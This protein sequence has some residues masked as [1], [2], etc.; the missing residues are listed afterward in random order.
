MQLEQKAIS[1]DSLIND[2]MLIN[3]DRLELSAWTGHIPFAAS[4]LSL[5]RPKVLVELGTHNG[6]SYCA[7]CQALLENRV[8][9]RCYAVDTWVGDEHAFHYGE[10]VFLELSRY[11]DER[12]LSIS[13]LLR[14][15]FDDALQY[16]SDATIDL[17]HIDGLHTY[18]AVR[19]D[20]ETWQPKLS[21]SGVV[22]FHDINVRERQFGVW[23]LW[24]E[25]KVRYPS[26]EFAHMHG[27]GVLFVGPEA[28]ERFRTLIDEWSGPKGRLTKSILA[29]LGRGLTL[30]YELRAALQRIEKHALDIDTVTGSLAMLERER[31]ALSERAA[32]AERNA[33]HAILAAELIAVREKEIAAA[34]EM[35]EKSKLDLDNALHA[36]SEA[37]RQA[38]SLLETVDEQRSEI[39]EA[40]LG[41]DELLNTANDLRS[42][43]AE[44]AAIFQER[45]SAHEACAQAQRD[46]IDALSAERDKVELHRDSLSEQ[47]RKRESELETALSDRARFEAERDHQQTVFEARLLACDQRIDALTA[48]YRQQAD[49]SAR[50]GDSLRMF[51]QQARDSEQHAAVNAEKLTFTPTRARNALSASWFAL[52]NL[53]KAR[54]QWG[55]REAFKR[56]RLAY[57]EGGVLGVLIKLRQFQLFATSNSGG[58][59]DKPAIEA[60]DSAT[61]VRKPDES[62]ERCEKGAFATPSATYQAV[63]TRRSRV[64]YVL[65]RH[66]LMTQRY[67]VY[68]YAEMLTSYGYASDIYVDEELNPGDGISA[69]LVILNR[70]V[71]SETIG[72]LI[73]FCRARRIPVIFDIDDLVFD[74]SRVG[75]LRATKSYG[76]EDLARTCSF[77]DRT[78]QTML[79]CDAVTVS[80][81]PLAAEVRALGLTAYV[82]PNNISVSTWAIA[83]RPRESHRSVTKIGYFSGTK[84]HEEDFAVCAH[85]LRRV[86]DTHPETKLLIVGHLDLPPD[87]ESY[88]GR[89]ERLP[90]MPHDEMLAVMASIDINLAPLEAN[91]DFTDCKSELK[92]FEAAAM[93]V[94]TI[95]SP[96]TPFRAIISSGYN[97][98]LAASD[99]EW[100]AAIS[101]LVCDPAMRAGM[102]DAAKREIAARFDVRATV[103]EAIAIYDAVQE[104]AARKSASMPHD[105]ARLTPYVTIVS[106]L[107][108]KA[109]EVRYFLEALYCQ[110]FVGR[111]EIVLIDDVSPDDSVEVVREFERWIPEARRQQVN[112][113][114][115]RNQ[116]NLGN[117]GSRN[118]GIAEA[119]GDIIVV[120]D[121]DCMFNRQFLSA[122]YAAH[123]MG[124]CD[125][126][127]G[128][129]N[130]ETNGDS[131]LS[132]LGRHE[133]NPAL[134][135]RENLPQDELNQA[136]FVNCITR[137]FSVSRRFV[138][139]KIDG[140]LFDDAF[141]YSADPS[142]GFG[143]EDVE[144]GV[145]LY[146][147]GARIKYLDDTVSIHVSHPSSA[148]EAEK[149][150]RSLRNYRRLF[151][152][153]PDLLLESRVWATRTYEAIVGW[154]RHVGANL[155]KNADYRWLEK[156]FDRYRKAPIVIDRSRRL[157]ILT[158]RWHVPHQYELYKT[159]HQFDL[160]TGAGTGI[161]DQWDWKQRPM[162]ANCR[163]VRY[164]EIDPRE[165]D[166]KIL[167]FD[168][169]LLHPELCNGMVPSDWGATMLW[170][171]R[172]AD[173]PCVAICHGTPQFAGQYDRAYAGVDLGRIIESS[174][175][176]LIELFSPVTVVCNSHQSRDEWGFANA[177]T[178]WHGFA[179]CDFP[180]GVHDREVLTMK[181]DALTNRPHYNG[182]FAYEKI[183]E[184]TQGIVDISCLRTPDPQGYPAD[185]AAWA[186][187]KYQNYVRE[188]GRYKAYLNT[189]LR[190]PM[191]RS[192]G[193]AMMAGLVSVSMRNH[194]V[195]L[196]IKNGANGF[197]GDSPAELAEQLVWLATHPAQA[198]AMR[199]A[200]RLTAMQ[201]FNQDRYLADWSAL[202]K[203][204][205]G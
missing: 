107:Y 99:D 37:K 110:D 32:T 142:S 171:L 56:A 75:L 140:D 51:E 111:Y 136:S 186:F 39:A 35:L 44:M 163:M 14:M 115:V 193:E 133:A 13:R 174:R 61:A 88:E 194:D 82:L 146:R 102:G 165:Y 198:E 150:L 130:I 58:K 168:E 46:E 52:V 95:A 8:D 167:H 42:R 123:S 180:P 199:R 141:S 3:P 191:P 160:M 131:P 195:D 169:N 157:R 127:I 24:D 176:E 116:K 151:E 70:I 26:I 50:L 100:Y 10:D 105:S 21:S 87:L 200:S 79:A 78:R 69:D 124:D 118:R 38:E 80:T 170:L 23:K 25:L 135:A 1:V 112:L 202:L 89:I 76:P 201:V 41:R 60:N 103:N 29:D 30:R 57:R 117:C 19:H 134:A 125:A 119:R 36:L 166:A 114:I 22:L 173:L 152:K 84:T 40:V 129:I 126:A 9:A 144:M 188:V 81:V 4:M 181:P 43:L 183:V 189:T 153:H 182:L 93:G 132:V 179:P 109:K 55:L 15:T 47:L 205:V 91:N 83:E 90:L 34:A 197:Y 162:P 185:T 85:A 94:P 71:W 2:G 16:F 122:H 20:F 66:D 159:G 59:T 177:T 54:A 53:K 137:N 49:E 128:P 145:R 101:R 65:N 192:R 108:R 74:I 158:H 62:D 77:I 138:S 178:I 98:Y 18:E 204:I 104:G 11:H 64:A 31:D 67:R 7:F 106:V 45:E 12:Y 97:G 149:P 175:R 164:D 86:L 63:E 172:N 73:E 196:F 68:N 27:L 184:Q 5:L 155:D 96:T 121:A 147:A 139:E 154:A 143:W 6:N 48:A 148:N 161:C 190:S 28:A 17:L 203:R 156:R 187:A 72:A 92:I 120:V 113:R 33:E